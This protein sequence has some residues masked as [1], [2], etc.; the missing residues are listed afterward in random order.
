MKKGFDK[1]KFKESKYYYLYKHFYGED[2]DLDL[3]GKQTTK[4]YLCPDCGNAFKNCS[5]PESEHIIMNRNQTPKTPNYD[6]V[7]DFNRG[8]RKR[9]KKGYILY[10]G[11]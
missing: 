10:F 11:Y 9:E 5:C 4:K 3:I 1:N 2:L 6:Y 7:F 8:K